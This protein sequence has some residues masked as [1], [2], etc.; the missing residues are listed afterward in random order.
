VIQLPGEPAAPAETICS[1]RGCRRPAQWGL[2]W[3]NPKL[4]SPERRKTWTA[5]DQHRTD[6][7]SFLRARAFLRDTVPVQELT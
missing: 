3:N 2:L 5:C 1:A 7:E 6:L 4:H